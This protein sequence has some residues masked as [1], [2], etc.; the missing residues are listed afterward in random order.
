MQNTEAGLACKRGEVFFPAA[1]YFR[2]RRKFGRQI[3]R[4]GVQR[5][6]GTLN[7]NDDAF[8][9]VAYRAA[10]S[11]FLCKPEYEGAETHP[12]HLPGQR[13]SASLLHVH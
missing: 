1:A 4:K 3:P 5:R 2:Q 6:R 11:V 12:L 7:L 9:A 13:E 10:E 8:R